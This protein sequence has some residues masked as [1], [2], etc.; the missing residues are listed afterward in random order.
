MHTSQS[1]IH[2]ALLLKPKIFRDLRGFFLESWNKESF[3]REG[4]DA[5]F[6]QDN[7]SSSLQGVLRGLHYQAGHAAQGKLVWVAAGCVFD[8][9]VDLRR[10]SPTYAKWEGRMLVAENYER[11]WIPPGCAHGF[12]TLSPTANVCYKVTAPR[13]PRAEQF[14]RWDDPTLAIRWPLSEIGTPVLSA[15]DSS[16]LSFEQCEKYR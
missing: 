11:L 14:L 2:Q 10:S 15:K 1:E 6:V 9:I 5:D 12:L 3:R 4:L 8:V 13:D 16:A 7:Q